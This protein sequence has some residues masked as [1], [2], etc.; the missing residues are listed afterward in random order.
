[1]FLLIPGRQQSPPHAYDHGQALFPGDAGCDSVCARD[2]LMG[3]LCRQRWARTADTR[4]HDRQPHICTD[5]VARSI[6]DSHKSA[7]ELL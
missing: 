3:E 2:G 5:T 1:M 6:F 4:R 7:A